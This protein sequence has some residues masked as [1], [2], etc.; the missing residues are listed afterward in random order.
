MVL[1]IGYIIIMVVAFFALAKCESSVLYF[2][3]ISANPE[4]SRDIAKENL[5]DQDWICHLT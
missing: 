3:C 4:D 1:N 2:F 5:S